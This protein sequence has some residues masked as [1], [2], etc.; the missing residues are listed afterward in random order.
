MLGYPGRI[1]SAT[2]IFGWTGSWTPVMMIQMPEGLV[3]ADHI[4]EGLVAEDHIEVSLCLLFLLYHTWPSSVQHIQGPP[5]T[6]HDSIPGHATLLY[7][8]PSME[9]IEVE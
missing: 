4:E 2:P 8:S 7:A 5:V 1:Y 9:L 6:P 3:G